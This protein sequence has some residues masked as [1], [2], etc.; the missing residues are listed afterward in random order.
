MEGGTD[1]ALARRV[2]H[3]GNGGRYRGAAVVQVRRLRRRVPGPVPRWPL[4]AAGAWLRRGLRR[5]ESG[6][7]RDANLRRC[8]RAFVSSSLCALVLGER[9]RLHLGG[10]GR[11]TA[12]RRQ[13]DR[14][15]ERLRIRSEAAGGATPACA[16]AA[17]ANW[18]GQYL[19]LRT[20]CRGTSDGKILLE[21][22]ASCYRNFL[23]KRY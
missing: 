13:T 6:F 21:S 16:H 17:Y 19:P 20:D 2:W 9:L 22:Q 15:K 12:Q 10:R 7:L 14:S 3:R 1:R 11:G 23:G 8:K 4:V 5:L 18:R